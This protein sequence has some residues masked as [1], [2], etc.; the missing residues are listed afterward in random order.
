MDQAPSTPSFPLIL[1]LIS[2]QKKI[3]PFFG[4][5]SGIIFLNK[6]GWN[7]RDQTRTLHSLSG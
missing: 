3:Q 4:I 7:E 5:I 2:C 6:G 1:L